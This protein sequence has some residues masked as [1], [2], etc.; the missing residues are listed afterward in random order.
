M[1]PPP[2]YFVVV[3][4]SLV[5]LG[6][7]LHLIHGATYKLTRYHEKEHGGELLR[8]LRVGWIY[9][10]LS[11]PLMLGLVLTRNLEG[12]TEYGVNVLWAYYGAS[13]II[14]I[15]IRILSNPGKFLIDKGWEFHKWA[16]DT[17]SEKEY[18]KTVLKPR[19]QGIVLSL[20]F[21]VSVLIIVKALL[22]TITEGDITFP[23]I[24]NYENFISV[25]SMIIAVIP[26][27]AVSEIFL[28]LVPPEV[29]E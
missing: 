19:F 11:T 27:V 13:Y 16:K 4:I 22:I 26:A 18:I 25:C 15:T 7:Y 6:P 17:M 23:D 1:L 9:L 28:K 5:F 10:I 24:L 21:I 8:W 20:S 12:L 2:P 3:V 14:L 29:K